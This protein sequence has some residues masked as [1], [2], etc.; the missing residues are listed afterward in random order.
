MGLPLSG[1]Y[2]SNVVSRI[3]GEISENEVRNGRPMLSAVCVGVSGEPGSGF[4]G[5]AREIGRLKSSRKEDEKQFWQDE[6][7]AVYAAWER[8]FN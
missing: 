2:M 6:L 7:K 5:W 1:S 8:K 3:I 4:Y